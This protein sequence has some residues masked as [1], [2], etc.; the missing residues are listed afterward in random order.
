[1]KGLRWLI[2]GLL[3]SGGLLTGQGLMIEAKAW[4][5]QGLIARAWVRTLAG[6]RQVVP[7]PWADTWPVAR[8]GFPGHDLSL[9]VLKGD[10]GNS[11]A[12]GPGWSEVTARPGEAGLSVIS[13]HR[14]THFRV[15]KDLQPGEI[16]TL[17][18]I[19]G[20]MF[21]YRVMETAVVDESLG[22]QWPLDALA[23]GDGALL[24]IT[25]YPFDGWVPGGPLRYLVRAE[26]LNRPVVGR[27]ADKPDAAFMPP[28]RGSLQEL[29]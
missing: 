11:L 18:T 23:A 10:Q 16:V 7:W 13:G 2:I 8:I 4:L 12:F 29:M 15:L 27:S 28:R 1:M 3:L 26:R 20:V 24:L 14:D 6:E 19:E 17:Q 5:A 9:L 25:C 22:L 21:F